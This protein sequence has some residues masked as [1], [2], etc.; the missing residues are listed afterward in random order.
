MTIKEA[1]RYAV[2]KAVKIKKINLKQGAKELCLSYIQMKRIWRNYSREGP[3]GL[4]SKKRGKPSNNQILDKVKYRALFL[5]KEKYI[6][7]GPTLAKSFSLIG[8]K[9]KGLSFLFPQC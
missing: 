9:N 4:I 8:F 6:D 1:D 7:Y 3:K 5:I 2:V